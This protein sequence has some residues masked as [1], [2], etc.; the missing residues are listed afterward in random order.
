M[1]SAARAAVLRRIR[2]RLILLALQKRDCYIAVTYQS[3][4]LLGPYNPVESSDRK[5]S[6]TWKVHATDETQ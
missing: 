5:D 4:R 6:G 1:P 2:R 3:N